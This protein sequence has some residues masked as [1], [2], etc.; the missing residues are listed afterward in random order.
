MKAIAR[1]YVWWP[2]LD[3]AIEN[4]AKS[5]KACQTVK[6]SPPKAPLHPWL[7]PKNPW[8]CIHV[9]FTGSFLH[10]MFMVVMDAHSKWSE[11]IEMRETTSSRTIQE[12]RKLFASYGLPQQVVTDNGPDSHLG[13]SQ[14]L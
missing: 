6:Q 14:C 4:Q 5:C 13:N 10:K 8:E 1:S 3:K 2:G 11:I 7:W 9:D 12:L